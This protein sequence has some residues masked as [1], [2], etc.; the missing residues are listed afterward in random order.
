MSGWEGELVV[1]ARQSQSALSKC[2]ET[3]P[4]HQEKIQ[5]MG[6]TVPELGAVS[7]RWI[8]GAL[9]VAWSSHTGLSPHV[10]VRIS[11]TVMKHYEQ[12]N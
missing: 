4:S 2:H 9:K 10:L 3:D 1:T 12:G 5:K 6:V 8:T 11:V 7:P